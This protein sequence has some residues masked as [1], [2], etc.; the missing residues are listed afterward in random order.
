MARAAW[1]YAGTAV[2]RYKEGADKPQQ[3]RLVALAKHLNFPIEFFFQPEWPEEPDIVYWRSRAAE[4][5]Y[6]REMTEQRMLWLCE[7]FAFLEQDV[8]FSPLKIPALDL[9]DFRSLTPD[10]IERAADDVRT[11]WKL[12]DLPIPDVSLALENAGIPSRARS[13]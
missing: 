13:L 9:P 4:T 5:K 1:Y 11:I 8:N 2:T 3:D 12:R 7:I 6:A 10:A